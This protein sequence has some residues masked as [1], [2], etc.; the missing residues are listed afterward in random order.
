MNVEKNYLKLRI[1]QFRFTCKRIELKLEIPVG[2]SHAEWVNF[3]E[4]QDLTSATHSN[5]IKPRN[6]NVNTWRRFATALKFRKTNEPGKVKNLVFKF[7]CNQ[8]IENVLKIWKEKFPFYNN[9]KFRTSIYLPPM[10]Y[11]WISTAAILKSF[12]DCLTKL[13]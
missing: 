5:S 12:R 9:V 3:K 6:K 13:S 2:S 10:I 1:E 8:R 4:M 7:F 11:F